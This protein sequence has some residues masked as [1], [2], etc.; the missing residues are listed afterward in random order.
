MTYR[1]VPV[2]DCYDPEGEGSFADDIQD[3]LN[4]Q[5]AHGWMLVNILPDHQLWDDDG[6]PEGKS[7]AKLIL[8]KAPARREI[9]YIPPR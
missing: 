5:E 7:G 6:N 1:V 9:H 8:H 3:F 2:V 4:E